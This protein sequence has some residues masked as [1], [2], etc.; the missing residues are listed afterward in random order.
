MEDGVEALL[1]DPQENAR[2]QEDDED[3]RDR[4][5]GA[6]RLYSGDGIDCYSC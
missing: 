6:A 2:S 4:R 5:A 1:G 3:L